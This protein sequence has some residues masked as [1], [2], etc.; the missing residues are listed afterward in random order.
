MADETKLRQLA[1]RVL[2]NYPEFML[3]YD[4]TATQTGGYRFAIRRLRKAYGSFADTDKMRQVQRDLMGALRDGGFTAKL[5]TETRD[6][7]IVRVKQLPVPQVNLQ[8]EVAKLIRER[9]D[10]NQKV[11]K[12]PARTTTAD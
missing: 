10:S 4:P 3:D 6:D 11:G 8:E 2:R 12:A 9:E 1:E 7:F 5:G